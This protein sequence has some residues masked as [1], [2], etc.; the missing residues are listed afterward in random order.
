MQQVPLVFRCTTFRMILQIFNVKTWAGQRHRICPLM[1]L[2]SKKSHTQLLVG[3]TVA[4][5][6]TAGK[7][8][9]LR[10]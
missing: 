4:Q 8:S 5:T 9:F 1:Y 2:P 10:E 6:K 3:A 7:K